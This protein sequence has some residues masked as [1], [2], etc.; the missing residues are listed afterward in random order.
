MMVD[1]MPSQISY[2]APDPTA[3]F[4]EDEK[5]D[6]QGANSHKEEVAYLDPKRSLA[7]RLQSR[8]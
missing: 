3:T 6:T 1:E 2:E 5:C 8:C 7:S 4:I